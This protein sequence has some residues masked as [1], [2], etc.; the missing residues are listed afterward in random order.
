MAIVPQYYIFYLKSATKNPKNAIKYLDFFQLEKY[1][2]DM[3]NIY[4]HDYRARR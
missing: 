2:I 4:V 1:S 3:E